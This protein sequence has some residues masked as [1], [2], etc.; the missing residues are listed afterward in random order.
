VWTNRFNMPPTT[1]PGSLAALVTL[2]R[3]AVVDRNRL[4]GDGCNHVVRS[5]DKIDSC[6]I[7]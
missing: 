4:R 3:E 1:S 7:M 6:E 2:H 5:A